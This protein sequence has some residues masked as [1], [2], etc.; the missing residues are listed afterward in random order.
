ML[1]PRRT[2]PDCSDRLSKDR[3]AAIRHVITVDRRDDD[4]REVEG[5][6]G[7]R[8]PRRLR[9]IDGVRASMANRAVAART[10]ADIAE[11]HE[12]RRPVRPAFADIGA[13]RL[14]AD[15]MKVQVAHQALEPEIGRRA[16]RFHF[17]PLG[18]RR[19]GR[20]W[21]ERD[22][23]GHV[24]TILMDNSLRCDCRRPNR[25]P[26]RHAHCTA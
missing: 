5:R 9:R 25:M 19:T 20:D 11:D 17:E 13:A 8:N 6:D 10:R 12:R 3:R 7:V 2:P 14:L 4:V 21:S 26:S 1:A 24:A 22:Y 15:R 16:R 23:P 18:F